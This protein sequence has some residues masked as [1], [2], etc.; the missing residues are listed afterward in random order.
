M[1][2]SPMQP[3]R[4]LLIFSQQPLRRLLGQ[5]F[6]IRHQQ[7]RVSLVVAAADAPSQLVQL[8]SLIHI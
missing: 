3:V 5:A 7:V 1:P 2:G 8:L 4:P 6:D